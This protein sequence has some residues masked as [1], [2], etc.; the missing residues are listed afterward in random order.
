MRT[1]LLDV[2]VLRKEGISGWPH[3]MGLS[4]DLRKSQDRH[5]F[6]G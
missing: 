2:L 5:K 4:S 3:G 1:G 6:R